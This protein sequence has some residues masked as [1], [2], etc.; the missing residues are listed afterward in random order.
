MLL[1]FLFSFLI[2]VYS[3]F[4]S[5]RGLE[6]NYNDL[7]IDLSD[8]HPKLI[9]HHIPIKGQD[10]EATLWEMMMWKILYLRLSKLNQF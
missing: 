5:V 3:T 2:L 10:S 7:V 6:T 9:Y 4:S 1:I 8:R